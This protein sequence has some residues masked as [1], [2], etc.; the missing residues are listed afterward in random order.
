M[1][2]SHMT[3]LHQACISSIPYCWTFALEKIASNRSSVWRTWKRTA[4]LSHQV[5]TDVNTQQKALLTNLH[6]SSE[7]SHAYISFETFF[8]EGKSHLT[9]SQKCPQKAEHYVPVIYLG[10]IMCP[11]WR[12]NYCANYCWK[13]FNPEQ[14]SQV[15]TKAQCNPILIICYL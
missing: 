7:F 9:L 13:I 10:G 8:Y 5:L 12:V 3:E 15:I 14:L 11:Q 6:S 4:R 2:L 1:N